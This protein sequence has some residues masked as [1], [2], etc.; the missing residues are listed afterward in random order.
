M[1]ARIRAKFRCI[2]ETT[3]CFN[4][5]SRI[6]KFMAMYDPDIPEDQRFATA[7]PSGTLEMTVDNPAARFEVGQF[8]Y[9]DFTPVD[10]ELATSV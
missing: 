5:D 6:V 3:N 4:P 10:A 8:Y 1:S 9:L 7:T 2:S